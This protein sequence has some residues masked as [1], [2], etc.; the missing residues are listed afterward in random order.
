M[1]PGTLAERPAQSCGI[2]P[3]CIAYTAW[4]VRE[5]R[6]STID[7]P[8]AIPTLKFDRPRDQVVEPAGDLWYA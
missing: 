4:A 7:H 5:P 3:G 1:D 2:V 6:Q 8:K